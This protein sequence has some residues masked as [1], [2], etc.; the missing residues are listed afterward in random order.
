MKTT[1]VKSI[2]I[3]SF[4]VISF[5]SAGFCSASDVID[6]Q[7]TASS[8]S[9]IPQQN[10]YF[11][12]FIPLSNNL[13]KLDF[14]CTIS[15][16]VNTT[17]KDVIIDIY[18]GQYPYGTKIASDTINIWCDSSGGSA[19]FNIGLRPHEYYYFNVYTLAGYI[20]GAIVGN[21]LYPSG[22]VW[23]KTEDSYDAYFITYYST[24]FTAGTP[25]VNITYPTENATYYGSPLPI[26][27]NYNNSADGFDKIYFYITRNSDF[28]LNLTP[29]VFFTSTTTG[30]ADNI[31]FKNI[32]NGN[33]TITA[34][35]IM[36]ETTYII[37]QGSITF[38]IASST[39]SDG[40]AILIPTDITPE[41]C[42][43]DISE[44]DD[45]DFADF[46]GGVACGF[47]KSA[48]WALCP[49]E[50]SL[51]SLS[52]AYS[53]LKN[54]FPFNAFFDLTTTV[55][56]AISTTTPTA[57]N[58][59]EMPF[60]NKS[61]D[62]VMIPVLSSSSLPNL[63]GNNNNNLFRNSLKWIL[64]CLASFV[65]FITIKKI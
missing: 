56:N 35:P 8:G 40:S 16:P 50:N 29:V 21:N 46:Y 19:I 43:F 15:N 45:I 6:Q 14:S 63:I 4:I 62:F 51:Q 10:G 42:L 24:T 28:Q 33:Y 3:L 39:F 55:S 36:K 5:F 20:R 12:S 17:K 58:T 49:S 61:G 52:N 65:I 64:W 38:N 25:L 23:P 53:E 54:S 27:F 41:T 11:Q 13:S 44:C 2:N 37:P 34:K 30:Y 18:Y 1:T 22:R 59:I 7:Q 31:V 47:K 57:N 48:I 26:T 9:T 32:S 60:I